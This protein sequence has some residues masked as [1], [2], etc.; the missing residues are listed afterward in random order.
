MS[1][2]VSLIIPVF[3]NAEYIG[4]L[5]DDACSQTY[6]ALELVVVDD[7]STDGTLDVVKSKMGRDS[8][9]KLICQEHCGVSAARNAGL[10]NSGGDYIGFLD[11]DDRIEPRYVELLADGL[12]DSEAELSVC[13]W[14]KGAGSKAMIPSSTTTCAACALLEDGAFFSSLWN[15]LF[16]RSAIFSDSGFAAFDDSLVIGED[17]EWLARVLLDC[18]DFAV[19]PQVLYHWLPREGSASADTVTLNARTLTEIRAKRGVYHHFSQRKDLEHLARCRYIW[20][21]KG[22]LVEGYRVYGGK[23]SLYQDLLAEYMAATEKVRGGGLTLLKA[24]IVGKLIAHNA[25]LRL[26]EW[27]ES[28]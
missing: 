16:T 21:M 13:G 15:K 25:P 26:F 10:A 6:D 18:N 27:V 4:C 28:L 17:E 24:R 20:T 2:L 5:L 14:D 8:R 7:G 3:N 1:Q 9:V 11:A 22:I 19:I 23:S 12:S